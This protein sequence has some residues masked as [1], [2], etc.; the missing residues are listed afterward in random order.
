MLEKEIKFSGAQYEFLSSDSPEVVFCS[1]IGGGKTFSLAAKLLELAFVPNSFG[2]LSAPTH[3]QV[4]TA[5]W[6]GIEKAF[7]EIGVQDGVHYV[8]NTRPPEEWGVKPFTKLSNSRIITWRSGS[9]TLVSGLDRFNY[10]RGAE[11]DYALIDEFRDLKFSE[12]WKVLKGRMRGRTFKSLGKLQQMFWVSTPPDNVK[13]LKKHIEK[14]GVHFIQGTTLDNKIN[15][16]KEYIKS[17]SNY[18]SVTYDREVLGKI[19]DSKNENLFAYNFD[20]GHHAIDFRKYDIE[21]SELDNSLPLKLSFDFNVDPVTCVVGQSNDTCIR[22][23]KSFSVS[24]SDTEGLCDKIL[25]WLPN[26]PWRIWVTGD[27]NGFN[28]GTSSSRNDYQ[29]IMD[30][31]RISEYGLM[32][33]RVNPSH[34]DSQ[35][36][37]NS[38]LQNFDVAIHAP[39]CAELVED[40]KYVTMVENS[41][42]PEIDKKKHGAHS[43]DNFRYFCNTWHGDFLHIKY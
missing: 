10:I 35:T 13:E 11:F 18:D 21:L 6:N 28:R 30:K 16:P 8:V 41:K 32:A 12:V 43:L 27:R 3:D 17:L 33:P 23:F 37:V 39:E 42:K 19:V 26:K 36:L 9:Y 5:T 4:K 1:G 38:L 15:L 14:D 31:L 24:N 2:L 29:I 40:L 22:I 34:R 20:E 25:A 7:A